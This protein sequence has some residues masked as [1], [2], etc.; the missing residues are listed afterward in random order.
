MSGDRERRM[1][2]L[3]KILHPVEAA[4]GE[5]GTGE[6]EVED[7][8]SL[9]PPPSLWRHEKRFL[10]TKLNVLGYIVVK[11]DIKTTTILFQ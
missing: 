5:E 6:D 3:E 1:P 8:P 11:I 9:P 4:T 7:A 2:G 10:S